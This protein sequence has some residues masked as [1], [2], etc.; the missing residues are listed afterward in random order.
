MA[1]LLAFVLL[2]GAGAWATETVKAD[3]GRPGNQGPWPVKL[4]AGLDGGFSVVSTFPVQCATAGNKNTSVGVTATNTPSTQQTGRK[5]LEI[6]NSL[7]NAGNPTVKC[8]DDGVA[9]VMAAGNAGTVLGVGDCVLY[10]VPTA[11]V[12]QCISDAAGTNVP[13]RECS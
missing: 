6:C 11:T 12:V 10:A 9:P 2:L 5:Y 13:T 4:E 7:Q 1:Y 8:R 3:Q